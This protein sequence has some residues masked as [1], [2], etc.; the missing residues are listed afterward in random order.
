MF[1]R[2]KCLLKG[3]KQFLNRLYTADANNLTCVLTACTSYQIWKGILGWQYLIN[4]E[5]KIHQ[6]VRLEMTTQ[7]IKY[8]VKYWK[9]RYNNSDD[10][11]S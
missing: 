5:Q 4:W 8:E 2:F 10:V 6:A 9:I 1:N 3:Y 11:R 7:I